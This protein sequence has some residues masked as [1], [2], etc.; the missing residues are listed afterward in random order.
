MF[1]DRNLHRNVSRRFIERDLRLNR[2]YSSK[3]ENTISEEKVE[4]RRDMLYG[5]EMAERR[6]NQLAFTRSQPPLSIAKLHGD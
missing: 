1:R 5:S 3:I 2:D 4:K 6:S